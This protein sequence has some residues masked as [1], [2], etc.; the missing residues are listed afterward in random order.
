[1]QRDAVLVK[2]CSGLVRFCHMPTSKSTST[3]SAAVLMRWDQTRTSVRIAAWGYTYDALEDPGICIK[4]LRCLVLVRLGTRTERAR[5]KERRVR[6][7]NEAES[8]QCHTSAAQEERDPGS[9]RE[10]V[11]EWDSRVVSTQLTTLYSL[12]L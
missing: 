10:A 4:R 2:A 9:R 3:E 6:L 1:M 11:I 12:D 7:A 8:K 5:D